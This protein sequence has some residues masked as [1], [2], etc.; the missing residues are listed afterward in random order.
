M[1]G[2]VILGVKVRLM[3]H[4]SGCDK[5]HDEDGNEKKT[6]TNLDQPWWAFSNSTN[7]SHLLFSLFT[8]AVVLYLLISTFGYIIIIEMHMKKFFNKLGSS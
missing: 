5:Q 3:G 6:N 1:S 2:P 7:S 8:A 4:V